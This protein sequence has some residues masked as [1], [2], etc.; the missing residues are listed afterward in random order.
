MSKD[1]KIHADEVQY[2]LGFLYIKNKQPKKA[3]AVYEQYLSGEVKEHSAVTQLN[4]GS[5]YLET[6]QPF[7]ALA[8]FKKCT[9]IPTISTKY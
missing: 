3:I 7:L 1:Y 9:S 4:L 6:N 5:L 2:Q 8:A